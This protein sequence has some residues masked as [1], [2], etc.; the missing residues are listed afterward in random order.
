MFFWFQDADKF[1]VNSDLDSPLS[2]PSRKS[3]SLGREESKKH[4]D[5]ED[6]PRKTSS[7]PRKTSNVSRK[8]SER[9][10]RKSVDKDGAS[11]GKSSQQ[12][13]SSGVLLPRPRSNSGRLLTD[14]VCT[15]Y[16][17]NRYT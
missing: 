2:P 5:K 7:L 6:T 11:G 4:S 12:E 9:E 13:L 1:A 14:E 8:S 16:I 15:V 3:S 17:E 10:T